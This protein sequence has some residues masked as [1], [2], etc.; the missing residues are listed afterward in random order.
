MSDSGIAREFASRA[1]LGQRT[2]RL[3]LSPSPRRPTRQRRATGTRA[4]SRARSQPAIGWRV[5]K[6]RCQPPTTSRCCPSHQEMSGPIRWLGECPQRADRGPQTPLRRS[7]RRRQRCWCCRAIS[8]WP[9]WPMR[10]RAAW[11]RMAR[12]VGC[13]SENR[14]VQAA[15][16]RGGGCQQCS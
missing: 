13:D 4:K 8:S 15:P 14:G 12:C 2:F 7:Q 16:Q 10:M 1:A 11:R 9:R 3:A 5:A 6:P